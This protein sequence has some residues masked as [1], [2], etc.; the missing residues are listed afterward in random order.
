MGRSYE[1]LKDQEK[2][3]PTGVT[4][5]PGTMPKFKMIAF[6][7]ASVL[8]RRVAVILPPQHVWVR[9]VD[10]APEPVAALP[11]LTAAG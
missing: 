2:L 8:D 5:M 3:K 11:E 7:E 9:A 10:E 1:R 6:P 4:P